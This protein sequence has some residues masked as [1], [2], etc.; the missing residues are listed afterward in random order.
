V[1]VLV[2]NAGSSSIKLA[3]VDPEAERE[4]WATELESDSTGV[5]DDAVAAALTELPAAP[6]AV[7]HRVVHGGERFTAPVRLSPEVLAQ[8]EELIELAPLH[9]PKA[10]ELVR[11]LQRAL[12][13]SPAVACFD[14]SFHAT[15]PPTPCRRAGANVTASGASASTACPTPTRHARPG[16]WRRR[17]RAS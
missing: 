14:T 6:D 15:Q 8:L 9:Q 1:R 10:L 3:L 7:G 13:E 16:G 2:A 17:E 5:D 11:A 4:E 12:P